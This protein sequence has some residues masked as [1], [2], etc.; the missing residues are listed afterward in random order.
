M[1]T[2]AVGPLRDAEDCVTGGTTVAIERPCRETCHP[3]GNDAHLSD[4][5][6]EVD[7]K[8]SAALEWRVHGVRRAMAEGEGNGT[9]QM[10][11]TACVL[12]EPMS[13]RD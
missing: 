7:R 6:V 1:K 3:D 13:C 5:E 10:E 8:A 2:M 9:R 11:S 12:S 4:E